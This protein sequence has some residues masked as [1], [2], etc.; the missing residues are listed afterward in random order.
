MKCG[1]YFFVCCPHS[2][3]FFL[4]I[5][6]TSPRYNN[7]IGTGMHAAAAVFV[8]ILH[9]AVYSLRTLVESFFLVCCFDTPNTR[10]YLVVCGMSS[11][12]RFLSTLSTHSTPCQTF[13][14]VRSSVRTLVA[15]TRALHVCSFPICLFA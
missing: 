7:I 2:T 8:P 11:M 13:F 3:P 12:K 15:T 6:I 14:V 4:P 1:E 9:P 5:G 10:G